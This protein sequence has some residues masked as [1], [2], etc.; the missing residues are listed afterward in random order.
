MQKPFRV[1]R[2]NYAIIIFG[3]T[4][5]IWFPWLYRNLQIYGSLTAEE[6]ANVRHYWNSFI[7]EIIIIVL[8]LIKSFWAVSG[9]YNDISDVWHTILG[10][11]ISIISLIGL[12]YRGSINKDIEFPLKNYYLFIPMSITIGVN[13]ILVFRFG[14][15]YNQGQGRFLFPSIIPISIIMGNGIKKLIKCDYLGHRLLLALL[16][17]LFSTTFVIITLVKI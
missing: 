1:Q 5:F 13:L 17:I 16:F 10:F 8:Y 14:L 4:A 6:I 7:E 9:Q 12:T 15:L 3:I 11:L 2:L